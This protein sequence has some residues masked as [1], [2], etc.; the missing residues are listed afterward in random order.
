MPALRVN[1][2]TRS[3]AAAMEWS[4]FRRRKACKASLDDLAVG[5]HDLQT[6]GVCE[7]IAVRRVAE[8]TLHCVPDHAALR[9]RAGRVLKPANSTCSEANRWTSGWKNA[10]AM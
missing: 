10:F 3:D 7:V 6:A 5:K 9:A 8:A 2:G 4:C 1:S